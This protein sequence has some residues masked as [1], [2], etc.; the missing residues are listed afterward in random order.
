MMIGLE[1]TDPRDLR[2]L[3]IA[4][5]IEIPKR[6]AAFRRALVHKVLER[7]AFPLNFAIRFEIPS[8]IECRIGVP[9]VLR[10]MDQEMLKGCQPAPVYVSIAPNIPL[11]VEE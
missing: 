2:L 9:Q 5:V 3:A 4:I 11:G 6:P 8:G 10:S 7:D 1:V